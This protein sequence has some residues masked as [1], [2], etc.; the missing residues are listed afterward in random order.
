MRI[1][2]DEAHR[3]GL[4]ATRY[5]N[6]TDPAHFALVPL[7]EL[8]HVETFTKADRF[9]RVL[10]HWA[11]VASEPIHLLDGDGGRYTLHNGHHRLRRHRELGTARVPALV[12]YPRRPPD[13]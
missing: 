9:A 11:T 1:P 12:L 6:D 13:E 8:A 3:L 7:S 4:C 2:L 10:D 5:D